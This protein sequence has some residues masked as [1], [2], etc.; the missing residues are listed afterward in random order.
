MLSNKVFVWTKV[1]FVTTNPALTREQPCY[2]SPINCYH[3]SLSF[4]GLIYLALVTCRVLV[5]GH[6][7]YAGFHSRIL[8][9]QI[10][11][12]RVLKQL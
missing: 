5:I 2:F 9:F 3:F 12:I 1:F 4:Y 11:D 10:K 6:L 8:W 7:P